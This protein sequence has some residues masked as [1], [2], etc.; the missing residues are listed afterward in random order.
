MC[1]WNIIAKD[2]Q[3]FINKTL[4]LY[5]LTIPLSTPRIKV[6]PYKN[7]QVMYACKTSQLLNNF[8]LYSLEFPKMNSSRNWFFRELPSFA[9]K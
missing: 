1:L 5:K 7:V 9:A 6:F 4:F 3:I 2:L 8:L